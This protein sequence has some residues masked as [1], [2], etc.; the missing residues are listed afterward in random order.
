MSGNCTDLMG[1]GDMIYLLF[2][3]RCPSLTLASP[4]PPC[5]LFSLRIS[6][7]PLL[8]LILLFA[9]SLLFVPPAPFASFSRLVYS[10]GVFFSTDRSFPAA[11]ASRGQWSRKALRPRGRS[12][13][14]ACG[15]NDRT[16]Q[17]KARKGLTSSARYLS[18][19][20]CCD[21][22]W[23][24]WCSLRSSSVSFPFSLLKRLPR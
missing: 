16:F 7:L 24:C 11:F 4:P 8:L 1:H 10:G 19:R 13:P 23:C 22:S 20:N 2:G 6:N 3:R 14:C 5:H 21:S 18:S 17:F 9:A 12:V 15:T